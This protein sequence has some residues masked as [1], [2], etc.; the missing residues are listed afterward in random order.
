MKRFLR[1]SAILVASAM[2][3]SACGSSD[4]QAQDSEPGFVEEQPNTVEESATEQ[5][6][7]TDAVT[8]EASAAET[9]T[10]A[11]G[12]DDTGDSEDLDDY[13]EKVSQSK[14]SGGM[15]VRYLV[16][17]VANTNA[18]YGTNVTVESIKE[19]APKT[20]DS[21]HFLPLLDQLYSHIDIKA[22]LKDVD[23]GKDPYSLSLDDYAIGDLDSVMEELNANND[24]L[25]ADFDEL[26]QHFDAEDLPA[27]IEGFTADFAL[28]SAPLSCAQDLSDETVA[29]A[30]LP[31]IDPEN[32]FQF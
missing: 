11:S 12:S 1:R 4:N 5:E 22:F 8:E 9:N 3:L 13:F 21:E 32:R 10:D 24:N 26:S 16:D 6:S 14:A 15:P 2:V 28:L 23:N 29:V 30:F 17:G 25:S 18:Q 31:A 27:D 19:L 20:C 7:A